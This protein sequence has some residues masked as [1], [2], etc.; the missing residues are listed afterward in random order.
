MCG[1]GSLVAGVRG[2]REEMM[3][4]AASQESD[5]TTLTL[6]RVRVGCGCAGNDGDDE[7]GA[8]GGLLGDFWNIG[9][10]GRLGASPDKVEAG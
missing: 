5:L 9:Q 4:A 6:G 7:V 10:R 8:F 3:E 2:G 1:E